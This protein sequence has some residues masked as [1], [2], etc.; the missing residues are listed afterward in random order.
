MKQ[1]HKRT[2][3]EIKVYEVFS[4]L[5]S[6]LGFI[7]V[8][9][10]IILTELDPEKGWF[11]YGIIVFL[12]FTGISFYLR[13]LVKSDKERIELE[14]KKNLYENTEI[15]EVNFK[16]IMTL[17]E[18]MVREKYLYLSNKYY[19]K[20][21]KSHKVCYYG[22]F[23]RTDKFDEVIDKEIVRFRKFHSEECE[24]IS[25][26]LFVSIPDIAKENKDYV[27]EVSTSFLL[28]EMF[29]VRKEKLSVIVIL[30]DE[31]NKLAYYFDIPSSR[32]TLLYTYGNIALK[33][34]LNIK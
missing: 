4:R 21:V 7:A 1:N 23:I 15:R 12:L 11:L 31:E 18:A 26:L 24:S 16:D 8:F 10:T 27:K 19:F 3:K 14:E 13:Q 22:R 17:K 28:A 25:A 33:K 20:N 34:I 29:P 6:I 5:F 30:L 2:K 9:S 32:R